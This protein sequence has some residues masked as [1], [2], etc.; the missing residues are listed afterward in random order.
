VRSADLERAA[1]GT[2]ESIGLA[3]RTRA[4]RRSTAERFAETALEIGLARSA[5]L[6]AR[7]RAAA[8]ELRP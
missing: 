8:S 2:G 3:L 1:A 5:Q 7:V 4:E 6:L